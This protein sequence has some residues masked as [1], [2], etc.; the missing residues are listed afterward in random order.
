[1][2]SDDERKKF[3]EQVRK[4]CHIAKRLARAWAFA[5][6]AWCGSTRRPAWPNGPMA[7]TDA[8][9]KK[10][11]ET[12]TEACKIAEDAG[13][14][15]AAEGEI[16]WGGM[17]SWRRML[18]LLEMVGRPQ[19]LGFQ[20]DMAHTLLYVL[21]H[22]AP[23][24]AILPADFDWKD[25]AKLDAA[26]KQLTAALRPWTIDF[27]VAQNDATVHGT[28]SHDKTGRHCL[29]NDPNGKLDI[30]KVAGYWLRNGEG[31]LTKKF[32][33]ICWDGCM[34]PNKTYD[35]IPTTWN[36]ILATMIAVRECARLAIDRLMAAIAGASGSGRNVH[37]PRSTDRAVA[38]GIARAGG[39]RPAAAEHPPAKPDGDKLAPLI[40]GLG[41][42]E[43]LIVTSKPLAQQYFNQGLRLIYAFNHDE[44]IRA[45]RSA[46]KLDPAAPMPQLG[47]RAGAGPQLQRCRP[48]KSARRP[49]SRHRGW[50]K[51]WPP[52][53]RRA[54]PP[55][56]TPW[57]S[58][59]PK[60]RQPTASRSTR[61]TPRPCASSPPHHP[62]DLGRRRAVRRIDDGRCGPGTFGTTTGKPQPGHRGNCRHA[63]SA[64]SQTNPNHPGAN[65]YYIHAVEASPDARARAGRGRRVW[66][67]LMPGGWPPGAHAGSHLHAALGATAT[68]PRPIAGRS[69]STA[70]TSPG[71]K[72]RR[73][74]PD[75]VL[76]AQHSLSVVRGHA[77]KGAAARR[78]PRPAKWSTCFRDE[79]VK[80]N[81][82]ARSLRAHAAV[83]AGAVRQVG[84]SARRR[85]TRSPS[86]PMPSA[87]GTT[88]EGWHWPPTAS[89]TRPKRSSKPSLRSSRPRP[90]IRW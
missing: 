33:H 56:P 57:P 19:T 25:T 78:S 77:W 17:H 41:T 9:T 30:V 48:T 65:H 84:R 43:H 10:I 34:F 80:R 7:I 54:R 47:N 11:A 86:L 75:D 39:A 74:V 81:A 68:P 21:G 58:A 42:H 89:S 13:E 67:D 61:P 36:T 72:P 3:L 32:E 28:G 88:P 16:C 20:A 52:A 83:R 79:M 45:F 6:T 23:E 63:R 53:D 82:D 1:M 51:N 14:R 66:A 5:P 71:I 26:L 29:P 90:R 60:T 85:Q 8:N 12:F 2:G 87:C 27:H 18:Q 24:D 15:L 73:R 46:A 35:W 69:K 62:D 76:S 49:L 50:R 64:C 37:E 4:G 40:D 70:S 38:A 44:A 59:M 55:M 22:N 31:Q